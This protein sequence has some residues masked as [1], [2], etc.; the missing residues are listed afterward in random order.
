[1]DLGAILL[2]LAVEWKRLIPDKQV[3]DER[4]T[5]KLLLLNL[6]LTGRVY[7]Q[8]KNKNLPQEQGLG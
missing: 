8:P 7:R 2:A 4:S 1:M 5:G 3:I 6:S